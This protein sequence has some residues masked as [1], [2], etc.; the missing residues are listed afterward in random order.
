MKS[1]ATPTQLIDTASPALDQQRLVRGESY[2][3]LPRFVG[4]FFGI[5]ARPTGL[6]SVAGRSFCF[7]EGR[8]RDS[9]RFA[10]R[11]WRP[12]RRT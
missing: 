11:P 8:P 7:G 2:R 4:F 5:E 10:I 12:G 6:S 1:N 3:P 9:V